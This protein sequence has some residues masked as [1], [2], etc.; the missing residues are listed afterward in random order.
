MKARAAVLRAFGQPLSLEE[1]DIPVLSQGQALA[2]IDAAGVCG[3]D[4]HMW[5][6]DDPRTP[7]PMIL[8]H[9]GIGRL[10]EVAGERHDVNGRP[11]HAGQRVLW[12]RG[13]TC[14]RCHF[15]AVL[16]EPALCPQRWVYGI[17]R[18][19][20]VPPHLNGCY[21][22][23]LVL[24]A[25]SV[26]FPVGE[27]GDEDAA[28]LVAASCSGATAAHGLDLC[29][30]RQGDTV[31]V[32]GPGPLGAFVVALASAAGAAH[33]VVVGGTPE[34]LAL[35]QRLG[36]TQVLH[37]NATDADE[38]RT[39]VWELAH[40]RGAD[41]VVEAAGSVAAAQEGLGLVRS[42]GALLLVGF[43][44]PVGDMTITPFEDVVRKNVR[45]QGVWVSDARHT[46]Q[47]LSLVRSRPE[48][49]AALVTHRYSLEEGSQALKA[50]ASH[51]A[52]KVVLEP[53]RG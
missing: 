32:F 43:G 4:V 17:H 47:A 2:A 28:V 53:A 22:T 24:D 41:L 23:H 3:S 27:D 12:E 18:G 52:M 42:G 19:L 49:F 45:V 29:P 1:I 20:N 16:K 38:R 33:I 26:L 51:D 46:F 39:V 40:G 5:R 30:V 8:G 6:G 10:V 37:R 21:T 31:V 25:S 14:G 44:T 9:E 34:R 48:D 50:M 35:C 36:A 13:V 11:V 15:C 7:L